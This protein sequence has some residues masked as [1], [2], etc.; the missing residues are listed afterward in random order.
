MTQGTRVSCNLL[1]DNGPREDLYV[2]VNHGP[3]LVDNNIFLSGTPL[4][5][6]SEGGAY[7]HNL[8]VG[9]VVHRPVLNRKTPYH[10]AHTT[11]IAGIVNIK[12]GDS[13]FYNNVFAVRADLSGY[14]KAVHPMAMAGNIYA[15]GSKESKYDIEAL[16]IPDFDLAPK[17]VRKPDG[18]YL[19]VSLD[20]AWKE[21][22]NRKLITTELLGKAV[23]PNLP[24]VQPD[25]SPLQIDTDYF[26]N[27]RNK[28]N[29]FPGPFEIFKSG[30]IRVW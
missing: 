2:E 19:D 13:R 18:W 16:R 14:D 30:T 26:G 1:H 29:P 25:G 12:G 8:I 5:D 11:E 6:M 24:F 4:L 7:V 3:F 21:G 17:L 23:I 15:K 9:K 10:K 22:E 28:K 20:P 27:K